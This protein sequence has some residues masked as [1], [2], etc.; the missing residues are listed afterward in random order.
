MTEKLQIIYKKQLVFNFLNKTVEQLY[1]VTSDMKYSMSKK[2][3]FEFV[4][5]HAFFVTILS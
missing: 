2:K 3:L 5:V 4:H 1:F